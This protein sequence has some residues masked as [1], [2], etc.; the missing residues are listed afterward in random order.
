MENKNINGVIAV[1]LTIGLVSAAYYFLVY[2]K[3]KPDSYSEFD[4]FQSL[5]TNL[6]AKPD[7]QG[8][9]VAPFNE[10]KNFAQFYNNNRVVIFRADKSIVV[11]G[12]Y[13]N[14]GKLITL[15]NG[16]EIEGGSVWGNLLQTIK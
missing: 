9:V 11:K 6:N 3:G 13:Q 16:K 15:D 7:T 10:K 14:G 2:K 12:T 1:G 5:Q 4:N 8:V